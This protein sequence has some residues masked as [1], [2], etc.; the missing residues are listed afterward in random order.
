MKHRIIT[1]LL[2]LLILCSLPLT[3]YA[4]EVPNENIE[5]SISVT[6]KHKGDPVPGGKLKLFHVGEVVEYDGNY[7]FVPTAEFAG[8]VTNFDDI[9]SPA[10]AQKLALYAKEEWAI[11]SQKADAKG[12][13]TFSGLD[14]GLYLVVQTETADGYEPIDPFLVSVPRYLNGEYVYDVDATSKMD[15]ITTEPTEEPPPKPTKPG[16]KLP[17]TGQL[18]WPVPLLTAS[19]L[20]L[21]ALGY[22]LR[23]GKKENYSE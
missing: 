21:L 2:A 15:L 18:N 11:D 12:N 22:L 4:H 7:D 1:A 23:F 19:G 16:G 6:M 8:C 10:L 17:Q 3:A 13:V 14:N 20:L 5:G 9:H